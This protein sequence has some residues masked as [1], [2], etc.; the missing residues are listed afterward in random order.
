MSFIEITIYVVARIPLL[1][2]AVCL[3]LNNQRECALGKVLTRYFVTGTIQHTYL[4]KTEM[5]S[6]LLCVTVQP[7]RNLHLNTHHRD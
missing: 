5:E 6:L 7:A 1:V 4:R 3:V 2:S